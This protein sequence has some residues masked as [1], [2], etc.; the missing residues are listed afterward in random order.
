MFQN[1]LQ[2]I[3]SAK[4]PRSWPQTVVTTYPA[5]T[6]AAIVVLAF[7]VLAVLGPILGP[8][9]PD[10]VDYRH[11]LAAP[12][13][14]HFL[15]TDQHGRDVLSRVLAGSRVSLAISVAALSIT[16]VVG[17]VLGLTAGYFGGLYDMVVSRIA[18][19]IFAFPLVLLAVTIV[20]L[21]GPSERSAILAIAIVPMTEFVRVSRGLSLAERER[22]YV[23]ASR[24]L[25]T[26][27][28][29]T[30]FRSM[31]PN[32]LGPLLTMVALGFAYAI[33]NEAAL[34]FLGLGAQ[35]PASS[36]GSMIGDGQNYLYDAPWIS[37]FPG[38]AVLVIVAAL[39]IL[40]DQVRRITASAS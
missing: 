8:Y 36:W 39:S 6:L 34:G 7:L 18:D 30:I 38:L 24:A 20:V 2:L 12:S 16:T 32:I 17:T 14:G 19:A 1:R 5:F 4:A 37:L 28:L 23:E 11:A 25:G 26:P 15:G 13:I 27:A 22:T 9:D 10:A 40:G 3:T 21:L 35:P 29:S 31:L 33:L